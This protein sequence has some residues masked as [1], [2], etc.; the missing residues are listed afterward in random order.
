MAKNVQISSEVRV[1][2]IRS[3]IQARNFKMVYVLMGEE[4]YYCDIIEN[5]LL[6]KVLT[7]EEKDFNLTVMY[8]SDTSVQAVV[9]AARR[10]P[11]F[12]EK[13]L[14]I[15]REAQ[16]FRSLDL[17]EASVLQRRQISAWRSLPNWLEIYLMRVLIMA[18][19]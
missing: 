7:P 19:L 10:Y 5:E 18:V 16:L 8:A 11:V 2:E 9:E 1:K 14:V 4:P 12:A 17:L 13:Q 15:I 6:A 3:Q